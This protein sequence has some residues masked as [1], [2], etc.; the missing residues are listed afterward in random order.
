M[1]FYA[2]D[3]IKAPNHSYNGLNEMAAT[4]DYAYAWPDQLQAAGV[5]AQKIQN[6][7]IDDFSAG[8]RDWSGD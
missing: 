5:K 8:L 4:S 3:P 6:R 2:M 1:S 7:Q